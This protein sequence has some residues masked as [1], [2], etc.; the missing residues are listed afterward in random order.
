METIY[1][2]LGIASVFVTALAVAT[3]WAVIKVIKIKEQAREL[4]HTMNA[5]YNELEQHTLSVERELSTRISNTDHLINTRIDKVIDIQDT[6][7]QEGRR[8]VDSRID[9]LLNDPKFCLN[10]KSTKQLIKG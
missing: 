6:I 10:N 2:A 7:H 1:F 3:V 4:D 9:K 5:N 8:Y